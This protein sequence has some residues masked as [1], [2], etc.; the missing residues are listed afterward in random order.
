[1][2]LTKKR[3][4]ICEEAKSWLGTP[5]QHQACLKHVGVD[6]AM[7]VAGVAKNVGLIDKEK[8]KAIPNYPKDWHIHRDIPMLTDLMKY[9]GCKKKSLESL[10]PGDIVVFKIGRVPS[11]LGIYLE[12]NYFIH[13]LYGAGK[14]EVVMNSLSADWIK[15]LVDV[16]SLPGVR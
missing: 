2:K 7:L 1:M 16:Y 14:K 8:F 12:D 10:L 3:K 15:R 13:A 5:W 9:F 6:C 4:K 11:H